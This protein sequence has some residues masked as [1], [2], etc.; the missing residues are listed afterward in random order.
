MEVM[1]AC[2][3]M[4]LGRRV[5]ARAICL[6][7]QIALD[8]VLLLFPP[9]LALLGAI[10]HF[11]VTTTNILLFGACYIIMHKVAI[12]WLCGTTCTITCNRKSVITL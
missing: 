2:A 1:L 11:S 10:L 12:Q 4:W 7:F 8:P 6:S 9:R 3:L 5:A